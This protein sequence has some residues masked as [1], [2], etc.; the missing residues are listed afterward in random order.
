M[1]HIGSGDRVIV[2]EVCSLLSASSICNKFTH[3]FSCVN[4]TPFGKPVVPDEKGIKSVSSMLMFS[5]FATPLEVRMLSKSAMCPS[6]VALAK[7]IGATSIII[8]LYLAITRCG[9]FSFLSKVLVICILESEALV[10]ILAPRSYTAD[11]RV[12]IAP[13]FAAQIIVKKSTWF[14]DCNEMASPR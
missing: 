1:C 2:S 7:I 9:F 14:G 13:D 11:H 3:T 8:M 5:Y 10:G 4:T 6:D 12:T